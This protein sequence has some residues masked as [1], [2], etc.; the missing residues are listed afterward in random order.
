MYHNIE[1]KNV[2]SNIIAEN[3][4][5]QVY[6]EGY[7]TY[8]DANQYGNLLIRRLH[9]GIIIYVNNAPIIWYIKRQN[10]VGSSSFGSDFVSLH[11]AVDI[12]YNL[13]YKL[14]CFGVDICVLAEVFCYNKYV[15]SN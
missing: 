2:E 12:I 5:A 7:H 13:S 1:P 4:F 6:S 9:S 11:I 3:I 14:R 10:I 15:V 8:V